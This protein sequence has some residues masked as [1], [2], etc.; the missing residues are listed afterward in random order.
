MSLSDDLLSLFTGNPLVVWLTAVSGVVV[1]VVVLRLNL[2]RAV[3][4]ADSIGDAVATAQKPAGRRTF[5]R[6]EVAKHDTAEDLWIILQNPDTQKLRVYNITAYV[7]E[8]PGGQ[9]ILNNAGSESTKGF[10]GPQHPSRVYDII[11]D[12]YIGDLEQ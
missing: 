7:E 1:L 5:N 4:K 11:E 9:A 3:K 2:N 10:Y 12:Y 8:H 6:K